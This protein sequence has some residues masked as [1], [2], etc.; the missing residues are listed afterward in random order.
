MDRRD[1]LRTTGAAAVVAGTAS[2]AA[3]EDAA[4]A[5]PSILPGARELTLSTDRST[6]PGEG[7]D[8]LARRIE[9]AT[10]GRYR[11]TI[12]QLGDADLSYGG[13][14]RH[15]GLHRAFHVFAGLPFSQGLETSALHTWLAVA[16]GGMLWE[17]LAGELG[18][19]P[20]VV[21]HTGP[22]QG[23]WA[24]ARLETSSDLAGAP[25]LAEG[26]A[27]DVLGAL[28]ASPAARPGGDLRATLADG[29]LVAAEWLGPLADV[30][31]DLQPPAQRLYRPGFHR[32]GML[33][34]LDVARPLWEGMS[35]A[36]RAIL[37]GCAAQEYQ[38]SLADAAAHALIAS[39]VEAPG[40]WPVRHAWS[41]ELGAAFERAAVEAVEAIAAADP[42]AQ[43]IHD[44]YRAFRRLLG[45][46]AIA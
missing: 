6:L 38:Q 43:R 27:G 36:D 25:I 7:A 5:A 9:T 16:G 34:S 24:A 35:A 45:D 20:L 22:S 14:W 10:G 41:D 8:R 11:I 29:R 12:Q 19:K 4:R 39:Q 23:V 44:S 37:E 18:F 26:L 30:V 2:A 21:G 17:E 15:A 40:K 1:F 31:P 42:T 46:G 28:G 13:V 3:A 33:L 32:H